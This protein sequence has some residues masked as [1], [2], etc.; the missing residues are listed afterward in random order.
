MRFLFLILISFNLYANHRYEIVP[1]DSG[2][3]GYQLEADS[4][5]DLNSKLVSL[6]QRSQWL[7]GEW[8]EV[9]DGSIVSESVLDIDTQ[10]FI[11]RYYHPTNFGKVYKDI[12]QDKT[13]DAIRAAIKKNMDCGQEVIQ[14]IAL[15][16]AKKA[17]SKGQRKQMVSTYTDIMNLL[18]AGVLEAAKD[19][20]D[21]INPDGTITTAQDKIDAIAKIDSCLGV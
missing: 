13:D 5:E 17:L 12:T 14:L 9:E 6:I 18:R 11:T 2:L 1:N 8:N 20:I 7:Q 16:N 4:M 15:N 3:A 19:D 21:A 10:T